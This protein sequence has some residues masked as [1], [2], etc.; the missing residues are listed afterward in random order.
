MLVEITHS[1]STHDFCHLAIRDDCFER[2]T[3]SC[4]S[5]PEADLSHA[6]PKRSYDTKCVRYIEAVILT[7][8]D[9]N[10]TKLGPDRT[11]CQVALNL[12]KKYDRDSVRAGHSLQLFVHFQ[13]AAF[14]VFNRLRE[15][16]LFLE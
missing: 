6:H 16:R 1:P 3:P 7:G 15:F 12:K 4:S 13:P 2:A 14:S 10:P 5:R 9:A 8:I 11:R